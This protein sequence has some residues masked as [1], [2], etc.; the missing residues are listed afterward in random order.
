M[1]CLKKPDIWK[2]S[3]T[4]LNNS[5][6]EEV[7]R[8]FRKYLKKTRKENNIFLG[9]S[10]SRARR[11]VHHRECF[12]GKSRDVRG[13]TFVARAPHTKAEESQAN[14]ES[15][16]GRRGQA[17]EQTASSPETPP[18]QSGFPQQADSTALPPWT[19]K[20]GEQTTRLLQGGDELC[21]QPLRT[22]PRLR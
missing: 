19:E 12:C 21:K 16:H 22:P 14:A 1:I 3:N 6:V 9:C 20:R 7:I 5:W 18:T 4:L 10:Y 17:G 8:E 13:L 15:P 2:L 11:G